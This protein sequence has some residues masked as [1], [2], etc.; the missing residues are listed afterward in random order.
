MSGLAVYALGFFLDWPF[1]HAASGLVKWLGVCAM[2][3]GA[4]CGLLWCVD[5]GQDEPSQ[6]AESA[7]EKS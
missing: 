7:D 2:A 4:A 5:A 1:E 3:C 6:G